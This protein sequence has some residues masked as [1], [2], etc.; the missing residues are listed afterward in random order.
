MKKFFYFVIFIFI[1]FFIQLFNKV[2]H[3]NDLTLET[4]AQTAYGGN[5]YYEFKQVVWLGGI[6]SII[7]L[8][9]TSFV[10]KFK[11]TKFSYKSD[12][13]KFNVKDKVKITFWD[14]KKEITKKVQIVLID[15]KKI[16]FKDKETVYECLPSKIKNIRKRSKWITTLFIV[17]AVFVLIGLVDLFANFLIEY[18]NESTGWIVDYEPEFIDYG[19]EFND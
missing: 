15:A 5:L 14:G 13:K 19:P 1:N 8:G 2:V 10:N 6:F 9:I 11:K 16:S 3:A 17:S 18:G 12:Y 7:T 4:I